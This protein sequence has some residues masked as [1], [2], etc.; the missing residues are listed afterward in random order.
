MQKCNLESIIEFFSNTKLL[1]V[2]DN[3]EAREATLGI[4]EE[5]F[6]DIF[7]AIDGQDGYKKFVENYEDIDLIITDINMPN[8]SGMDMITKIKES[9]L[10][11]VPVLILSAHNEVNYF[12]NSIKVGVNGYLLKPIDIDQFIASLCQI[13]QTIKLRR[14]LEEKTLLLKQYQYI[15]DRSSIVSKTDKNGIITYVNDRFCKISKYSRDELIGKPHNIVRHPDTPKEVFK[16]L[17][18]TIKEKKDIW[19]GVLKNRIKNGKSCYANITISPILD[20]KGNIKE[21]ISLRNAVT[22]IIDPKKRLQDFIS[23]TQKSAIAYFKIDN[24]EDFQFYYG[25]KLSQQIEEALFAQIEKNIPK[26]LEIKIFDLGEG[27]LVLAKNMDKSDKSD[28]DIKEFFK[29]LQTKLNKQKLQVKNIGYDVVIIMSF[30]CGINA[31]NDAKYGI[32]EA[33]KENKLFVVSN[34]FLKIAHEKAEQNI[35]TMKMVKEAINDNRVISLFQPIINNQTKEIEKYESLVRIIDEKGKIIPPFFFLE[36]AKKGMYYSSLTS[37]I[38]KNSFE[39]LKLTTKD[40]SINL[41]AYDIEKEY[42]RNKIYDYLDKFHNDAHRVIFEL[43][44]SEEIMDIKAIKDFIKY[45]KSFGVKIAID[46][47][48]SGYS[49]IKRFIEYEPDIIKIDG[50]LIKNLE[51]DEKLFSIVKGLVYFTKE[52]HIQTVGEFVENENIYLI[53]KD[54]GIDYSQGYY[55]GK[56]ERLK[57]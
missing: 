47:F 40:I 33:V 42:T 27:E 9:N 23:D 20:N 54:L 41:S 16:D 30:A 11:E 28:E 44:E 35:N 48:G 17:W 34:G 31:L 2:E 24:F 21:Y 4:F 12:I 52:Q 45:V 13:S 22:D 18:H 53:L 8:M 43:L 57:E 38:L 14:E 36:I 32:K 55:F 37:K 5:F 3:K 7:V 39:A 25:L 10:K 1:Y 50:S 19:H 26:E 51:H 49:N 56:P 46:D 15:V 6:S 29:D